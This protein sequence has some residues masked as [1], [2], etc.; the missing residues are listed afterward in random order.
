MVAFWFRSYC[1]SQHTITMLLS[2]WLDLTDPGRLQALGLKPWS[3]NKLSLLQCFE[4]NI[5]KWLFL[6]ETCIL[7]MNSV[8]KPLIDNKSAL[9]QVMSWYLTGKRPSS[10]QW[11][12]RS[13]TPVNIPKPNAQTKDMMIELLHIQ[14]ISNGNRKVW[15]KVLYQ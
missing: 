10:D 8:P 1:S 3:W 2:F 11:S 15:Y 4:E 12:I 5:F 7:W 13:I 9:V 6:N 14:C